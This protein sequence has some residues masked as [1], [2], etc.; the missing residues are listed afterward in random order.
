MDKVTQFLEDFREKKASAWE[1]YFTE[2]GNAQMLANLEMRT[3][4]RNKIIDGITEEDYSDG[5]VINEVCGSTVWIFGKTH[6]SKEICIKII[7]GW[8]GAE[9]ICVSFCPSDQKINY[10]FKK[11]VA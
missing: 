5:P 9:A 10:P 6:K 11:L 2:H 7:V 4:E 8:Y 3:E 1:V